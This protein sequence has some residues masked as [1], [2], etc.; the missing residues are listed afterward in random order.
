VSKQAQVRA[1]CTASQWWDTTLLLS[2]QATAK[3]R[4]ILLAQFRE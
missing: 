2:A 3:C 1:L 4:A